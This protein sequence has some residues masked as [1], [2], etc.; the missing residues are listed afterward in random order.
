MNDF[1]IKINFKTI[2]NQYIIFEFKLINWI[3]INIHLIIFEIKTLKLKSIENYF[4]INKNWLNVEIFIYSIFMFN[5]SF[6]NVL[7]WNNIFKFNKM[8]Y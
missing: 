4:K 1:Y 3:K 6:S 8:N 5:Y 2:S 7:F